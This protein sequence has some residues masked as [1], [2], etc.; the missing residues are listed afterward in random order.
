MPGTS[1]K[2]ETVS[3]RLKKEDA[4]ALKNLPNGMSPSDVI[5]LLVSLYLKGI[6]PKSWMRN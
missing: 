2:T 3:I 5:R 4:A 1:K 6:I